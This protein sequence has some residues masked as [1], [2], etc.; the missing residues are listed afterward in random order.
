MNNILCS[1]IIPYYNVPE[2]L[3]NKCLYTIIN[4]D[5]GETL[6]E[7]IFINDGSII[8]ISETTKKLFVKISHF[9]LIEQ[10]NQGP[11]V[12]RNQG[13][14]CAKGKYVFF[15]D[16][17]DYWIDNQL[18]KLLPYLKQYK[19]DIIQF[20]TLNFNPIKHRGL[21]EINVGY[22]YMANNT[23]IK[24]IHTYCYKNSF[25]K[26]NKIYM[27]AI[28]NSE[29]D[30]FLF[31]AF[32]YAKQCL[33]TNIDLYYYL[34]TRPSSLT[35]QINPT[36]W[37]NRIQYTIQG[38]NELTVFKNNQRNTTKMQNKALNRALYTI[39]IDLIYHIFNSPLT[40][41]NKQSYLEQL[42]HLSLLPF[43]NIS[44]SIKYH[45]FRLCSYNFQALNILSKSINKVLY[46][47]KA[48]L[49]F[50]NHSY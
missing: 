12:A 23:L 19:Y 35:K 4:Q 14:R 31:Y 44:H 32:Y 30:V 36:D 22:E 34:Q 7:V 39:V 16:P 50:H 41:Q 20:S 26:K 18:T 5:W 3:V 40:N 33:F 17:D 28:K 9:T 45:L 46:L 11:G 37:N 2:E 1:I 6:Y 49:S 43:P 10:E 42:Y 38:L 47:R 15:V 29:D 24:G 27:P 8:P 48:I 21:F 25:L 13:I